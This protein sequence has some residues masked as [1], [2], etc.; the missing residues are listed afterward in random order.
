MRPILR[1]KLVLSAS[2]V[3]IIAATAALSGCS[4]A[5]FFSNSESPGTRNLILPEKQDVVGGAA[6][7]GAR[8]DA[9]RADI[10]A[11]ISFA[12]NLRQMGGAQQ[13]VTLLKEVVMT[14]PDNPSVLSEYGKAL[15]AVG[16]SSD[17][18][19]FFAQSVQM[20]R[21]DWTTFSAYG[22]ALDQTG[23][24]K[25]AQ[26]NYFI[27]LD[28]SPNNPTVQ[29]NLAMSYVLGGQIAQGEAI[30]RKLV[31]RPD[32]TAQMR[33]NLAMV[34]SL[35]GDKLE[36][37][38]LARQDLTGPDVFNNLAVMRQLSATN[39]KPADAPKPPAPAAVAPAAKTPPKET[40][41]AS[42]VP[43][44]T[45]YTPNGAPLLVRPKDTSVLPVPT[46][47]MAPVADGDAQPA[48]A[49]A[50]EVAAP[51]SIVAPAAAVTTPAAPVTQKRKPPVTMAPIPDEAPAPAPAPAN[52][53]TPAPA[54]APAAKPANQALAPAV[55]RQSQKDETLGAEP[56]EL[57]VSAY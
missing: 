54:A 38:K 23:A 31:A 32:A 18:I 37:E 41:S 8:Y 56:V 20:D 46:R 10:P 14:A 45:P 11:A 24:H 34:A 21:R 33:Q 39:G 4:G 49:V 17:A 55:L 25:Q 29:G 52:T 36:A 19:P 27:A 40:P 3:A 53:A 47:P 12:R 13:A 16:R 15:T 9:N 1:H 28:L 30:L 51:K 42:L 35:K 50:A 48:Q 57:A 5:N 26:D 22:V 44:A 2:R 43:A 7:W 6:Y